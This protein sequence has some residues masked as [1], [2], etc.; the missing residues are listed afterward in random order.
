MARRGRP[1]EM[2]PQRQAFSFDGH[3][4]TT[5]GVDV[6]G[7]GSSLEDLRGSELLQ[8]PNRGFELARESLSSWDEGAITTA[9]GFKGW[10]G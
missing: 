7:R 6:P 10:D 9:E 3:Y 8:H 2:A 5:L 1:F 4:P